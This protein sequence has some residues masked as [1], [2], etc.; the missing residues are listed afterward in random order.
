VRCAVAL[1]RLE[2][3]KWTEQDIDSMVSDLALAPHEWFLAPKVIESIASHPAYAAFLRAACSQV[4]ERNGFVHNPFRLL[5]NDLEARPSQLSFD[6]KR[7]ELELPGL[8]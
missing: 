3:G 8:A 4:G 2:A 7:R 6:S 1:L 5:S